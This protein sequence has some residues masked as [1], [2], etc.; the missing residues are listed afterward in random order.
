[1][2]TIK[3]VAGIIGAGVVAIVLVIVLAGGLS[4]SIRGR[5]AASQAPPPSMISSYLGGTWSLQPSRSFIMSVNP[6]TDVATVTFLNGTTTYVNV[7][8][9]SLST[10]APGVGQPTGGGG[11]LPLTVRLFTY[12]GLDNSQLGLF[13][14][15]YAN[16]SVVQLIE[17][18]VTGLS[19]LNGVPYYYESI[20]EVSFVTSFYGDTIVYIITNATTSES[21][22]VSLAVNYASSAS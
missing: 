22:L 5:M 18:R 15:K 6:V 9:P 20:G 3:L 1:M 19:Q 7:S 12:V 17:S 11:F 14:F 8:Q 16:A 13:S 21:S 4:S 2:P 10:P